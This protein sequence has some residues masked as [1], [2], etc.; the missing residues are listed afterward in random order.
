M[1]DYYY[2]NGYISH[3]IFITVINNLRKALRKQYNLS[4]RDIAILISSY[5]LQEKK[6]LSYRNFSFTDLRI[7]HKDVYHPYEIYR[8]LENLLYKEYINKIS[9][10]TYEIRFRGEY[11]LSN[12]QGLFQEEVERIHFLLY[13]EE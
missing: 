6:K 3:F 7:L 5:Q 11:I 2:Q 12:Y 13:D 10:N 1:R 4:N 8:S 9:R